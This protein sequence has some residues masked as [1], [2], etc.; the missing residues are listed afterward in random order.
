M[1]QNKDTFWIVCAVVFGSIIIAL[2]GLLAFGKNLW[3]NQAQASAFPQE[4]TTATFKT[5]EVTT[6]KAAEQ[7]CSNIQNDISSRGTQSTWAGQ[8]T[9]LD[10]P[11]FDLSV[12][13]SSEFYMLTLK[14]TDDKKTVTADFNEE[15]NIITTSGTQYTWRTCPLNGKMYAY[16]HIGLVEKTSPQ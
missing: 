15:I 3:P 2:V 13:N 12:T 8:W 14:K 4:I 9:M 11:Q 10:S 7:S 1:K 16:L 5:L 6:V